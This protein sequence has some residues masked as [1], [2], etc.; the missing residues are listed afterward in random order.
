MIRYDNVLG[1][2]HR[3]GKNPTVALGKKKAIRPKKK[4]GETGRR[5]RAV[6]FSGEGP[7][8]GEE[9]PEAKTGSGGGE[10]CQ[11]K[12]KERRLVDKRGERTVLSGGAARKRVHGPKKTFEGKKKKKELTVGE[13]L[14]KNTASGF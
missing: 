2:E 6:P 11:Q 1:G 10:N 8:G 7:G 3:G 13:I 14:K 5:K 9:T 12:T 4:C